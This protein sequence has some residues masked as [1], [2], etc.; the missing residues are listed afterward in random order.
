MYSTIS[1]DKID[2]QVIEFIY[3]LF[4][5]LIHCF[6]LYYRLRPLYRAHNLIGCWVKYLSVIGCSTEDKL[7]RGVRKDVAMARHM[8]KY[9]HNRTQTCSHSFSPFDLQQAVRPPCGVFPI[10]PVR[11]WT[12]LMKGW[13][14]VKLGVTRTERSPS[15]VTLFRLWTSGTTITWAIGLLKQDWQLLDGFVCLYTV[16]QSGKTIWPLAFHWCNA[17]TS[18]KAASNLLLTHLHQHELFHWHL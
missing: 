12:R 16:H 14:L 9:T 6:K 3:K 2:K 4:V 1:K 15:T 10:M 7:W 8:L 11:L 5:L 17:Q 13:H 18:D